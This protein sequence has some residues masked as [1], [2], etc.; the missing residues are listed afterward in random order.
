MAKQQRTRLTDEQ[1]K[2]LINQHKEAYLSKKKVRINKEKPTVESFD[3]LPFKE[4]WQRITP[5]IP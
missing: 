3:T 4:Q 2:E 1:K 5:N